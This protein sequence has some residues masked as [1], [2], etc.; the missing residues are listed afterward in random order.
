[1]VLQQLQGSLWHHKRIAQHSH[2]IT[3][4]T[5]IITIIETQSH[6]RISFQRTVMR[7]SL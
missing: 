2:L 5:V 1:M 3:T 4:I 7:F 6:A